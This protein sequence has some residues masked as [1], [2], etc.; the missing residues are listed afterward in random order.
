MPNAECQTPDVRDPLLGDD[1]N[2]EHLPT[3][4]AVDT[5]KLPPFILGTEHSLLFAFFIL[6]VINAQTWLLISTLPEKSEALKEY[7]IDKSAM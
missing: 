3:M 1:R 2:K 4:K 7:R 5:S 6:S